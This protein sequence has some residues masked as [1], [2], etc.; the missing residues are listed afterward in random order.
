M[1]IPGLMSVRNDFEEKKNGKKNNKKTLG[2]KT[3]FMSAD[4]KAVQGCCV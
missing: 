3:R 1:I 4:T 2:Q